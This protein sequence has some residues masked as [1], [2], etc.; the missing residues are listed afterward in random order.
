MVGCSDLALSYVT[1]DDTSEN[2]EMILKEVG[3]MIINSKIMCIFSYNKQFLQIETESY[4]KLFEYAEQLLELMDKGGSDQPST[5][6]I[7]NAYKC[8]SI[9]LLL[10]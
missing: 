10:F 5:V 3:L 1:I 4:L 6:C 7:L 2:V 8:I 9:C